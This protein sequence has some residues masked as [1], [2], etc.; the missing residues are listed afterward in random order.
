MSVAYG[1]PARVVALLKDVKPT[2]PGTAVGVETLAE[3]VGLGN[4]LPLELVTHEPLSPSSLGGRGRGGV[5]FGGE[6]GEDEVGVGRRRSSRLSIILD[7]DEE[8]ED[9]DELL[10]SLTSP[11]LGSVRSGSSSTAA[12]RR[13]GA[14]AGGMPLE[15]RLRLGEAREVRALLLERRRQQRRRRRFEVEAVAVMTVVIALL[16]A[17]FFAGMYLGASRVLVFGSG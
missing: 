4:R 16:M 3:A 6:E 12:G 11:L 10:P 13:T 5:G 7:E 2:L 9:D 14:A 15:D 1:S 17:V 8:D